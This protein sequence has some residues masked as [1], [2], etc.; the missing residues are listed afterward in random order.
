MTYDARP[1]RV[2]VINDASVARGGATGLALLSARM[3]RA[4][5]VPVTL[6]C[7]DTG[8]SSDLRALGVEI[9]SMG[10]KRL[11]DT[12][13]LTAM[14][15]GL[16]NRM[17]HERVS[18]YVFEQD[19]PR[20][21]YHV[22][23]WAQILSPALFAALRPVA[24]RVMVHAHDMFLGCPNGVYMDFRRGEV[25]QRV[26]LSTACV[27]T[28]CDKRS[29]LQKL[30]RVS[31]HTFLQYGFDHRLG[32]GPVAMIHPA[33]RAPLERAGI[34]AERLQT[35]RNPATPWCDVRIR[36]EQNKGVVYVGRL[37]TEKGVMVLAEVARQC[38]IPLTVIGDGP[39][40]ERLAREYPEVELPGWLD[41]DAIGRR[42]AQSRAL[43]MPSLVPETFGL[44]A[45]EA[46]LSGL[47]VIVSDSALISAEVAGGSLG[48]SYPVQNA[49][50]LG[51]ALR[52]ISVMPDA[53]VRD[54]SERGFDR[55]NSFASSPDAWID[56]LLHLYADMLQSG[57]PENYQ[58]AE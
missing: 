10:F 19:T 27:F 12:K 24:P 5:N 29:Y 55:R 48:L 15:Q 8:E 11:N 7:G 21:V 18:R 1:E 2:V 32:W 51:E 13:P 43:V 46:S 36:A 53:K 22:H 28:N 37:E 23:G 58:A 4:R 42:A 9:I 50:G 41:R 49:D 16:W 14:T 3:L 20:T 17:A 38:G 34:P 44:V 45:A 52:E 54:I 57:L 40:R 26:P 31:R 25:C 39:E 30:W 35:V 47:P 56:Q 6:I 33:M